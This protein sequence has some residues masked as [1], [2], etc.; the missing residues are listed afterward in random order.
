VE[1]KVGL[2]CAICASRGQDLL[3]SIIVR[4]VG[5]VVQIVT[6]LLV[7]VLLLRRPPKDEVKMARGPWLLPGREGLQDAGQWL[8]QAAVAKVR[9]TLVYA[10][11]FHW[12]LRA[13]CGLVTLGSSEP[14]AC[15]TP[16]QKSLRWCRS[17]ALV[18][19][20]SWIV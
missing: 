17:A 18:L 11:R 20:M 7:V 5:P 13:L 6:P 12:E 8:S 19:N 2:L 14:Q 1:P 15:V 10:T 3:I 16:S 4:V 9:V